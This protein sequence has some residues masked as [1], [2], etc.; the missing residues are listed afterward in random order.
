MDRLA[1]QVEF[2]RQFGWL[3]DLDPKTKP[4]AVLVLDPKF[5][6]FGGSS[7]RLA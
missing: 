6:R 3:I 5:R 1:L 7:K 4:R 2:L